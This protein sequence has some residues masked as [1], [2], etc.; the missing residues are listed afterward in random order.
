MSLVLNVEIL[1]EF[2]KLTSASKGAQTELQG[3]NKKISGFASSAGKAFASIGVGLSFAL[4]ARELGEATKAA[5]E[6]R[7]SQE[8]LAISLR[9]TM[10]AT[11]DQIASVEESIKQLSLQ[12]A[13][14]DD[15]L[16]PAYAKLAIA[17]KD[18]G[19]TNRLMAI[20]LDASAATGKSLDQVTQAMAK[21]LAGSDTALM[22]LIPSLKNSKN[23]ID[24]MAKAFS[25]ASAA[26]ANLDPYQKMQVQFGE[27]QEEIGTVLLPVLDEFVTWLNTDHGKKFIEDVVTVTKD[28]LTI[29]KD[30]ALWAVANKDWLIP[31]VKGIAAVT[32][33]WKAVTTAVTATR[34]AIALATAAQVAFNAAASAGGVGGVGGKGG[35][36]ATGGKLGK[37]GIPLIGGAM[38]TSIGAVL[39]IPG[40]TDLTKTAPERNDPVYDST[41]KLIAY[42]NSVTG[43]VTP[44]PTGTGQGVGVIAPG[45]NVTVNINQGTVT[46]SDLLGKIKSFG[47]STGVSYGY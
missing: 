6:D 27:I 19:E 21:S 11:D 46:G 1:G 24:D 18:V 47:N 33:A 17:T 42:K 8:L 30:V 39:V 29:F 16:R 26:A 43:A 7:K 35:K 41:G 10:D 25:G 13:V 9:N 45:N 32:V 20:A 36:G 37:G 34:S 4:I 31:L 44:V 40:S 3:L 38:A 28:L 14:A 23:P 2:K 15:E 5:V 22:K 12:A